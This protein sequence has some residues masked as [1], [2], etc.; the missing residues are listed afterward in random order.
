MTVGTMLTE[1]AHLLEIGACQISAKKRLLTITPDF[2]GEL[3]LSPTKYLLNRT[4]TTGYK[5]ILR[6][7]MDWDTPIDQHME[8]VIGDILQEVFEKLNLTDAEDR[9]Q[10]RSEL[11]DALKG[12]STLE[13]RRQHRI[14]HP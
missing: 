2:P 1:L 6:K 11:I 9:D 7:K 8:E 13:G 5:L 14:E 12:Q 3:Q 4:L 10:A